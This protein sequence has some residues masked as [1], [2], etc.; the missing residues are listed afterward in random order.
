MSDA[1]RAHHMLER[2]IEKLE[3]HVEDLTRAVEQLNRGLIDL[4]HDDH[5]IE[6]FDGHRADHGLPSVDLRAR[7]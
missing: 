6:I 7:G 2:R 1:S 4:R 3:Q 5:V